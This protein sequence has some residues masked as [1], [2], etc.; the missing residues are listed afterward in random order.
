MIS[1]AEWERLQR[2]AQLGSHLAQALGQ[3]PAIL[4][5]VAEGTLHPIMAA[6]GLW[7]D[8]EDLADLAGEIERNRAGQ[9]QRP[10]PSAAL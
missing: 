10:A 4:A 3:D 8:E 6:F 2:T 9:S 7:R 5:A 1:P